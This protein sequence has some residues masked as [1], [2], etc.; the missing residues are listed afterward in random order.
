MESMRALPMPG[1]SGSLTGIGAPGARYA[2]VALHAKSAA[3]CIVRFWDNASAAS[4]TIIDVIELTASG[5]GSFTSYALD[6]GGV[7]IANGIYVELV[8]GTMPEGSI[9]VR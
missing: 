8:S 7:F 2:G 4:G 3:S 6:G 9:R 1:A 5:V